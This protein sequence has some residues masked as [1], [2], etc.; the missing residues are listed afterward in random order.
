M[1]INISQGLSNS[2]LKVL[3]TSQNYPIRTIGHIQ[4]HGV[5]LVLQSS[6]LDII[7]VSANTNASLG[8]APESLLGKP[9]TVIFSDKEIEEL[10]ACLKQSVPLSTHTH[11]LTASI[12]GR[13]FEICLHPQN[14]IILLELEPQSSNASNLQK[15]QQQTCQIM[16]S[17]ESTDTILTFSQ[18]LAKEVRSLTHFDR[19]MIYQFLPDD[20]GVVIAEE[21]QENLE[22]Y[23]GLHYPATDIPAEARAIFLDL[24]VRWIPDVSYQPIPL[25]SADNTLT[26]QPL[27]LSTAWLRGVSPTHVEYLKNMGVA[28]S[29]TMPLIDRRGLWGLIACHHCQPTYI[30]TQ[31]RSVLALV[32]KIAS[33]GLLRQQSLENSH[34]QEKSNEL[35]TAL[36][37]ATGQNETSLHHVLSQNAD[38]LLDLFRA[39]GLA[40]IFDRDIVQVGDTPSKEDI[41]QLGRWLQQCPESVFSTST[42]R[43]DYPNDHDRSNLPA[44][45]LSV[46]VFLQK[47]HPISYCIM[48]FRAEQLK[49][50]S[51]AG[52]LDEST[53]VNEDG[54]LQLCPR[55]SFEIWKE[56]ISGQSLLWLSHELEAAL[57]LHS[58]LMLAA[59]NFSAEALENATQKAEVANRAK[60]EFLANMSHEIR[61]PMNGMLGMTELLDGT[62][63]D[64][65]QQDLVE[66]IR[67][68]GE[69]LLTVINDILDF[70]KIESNNL[71]LETGQLDLHSCIEEVL[72]LF[73]SQAE[74]KGLSLKV[75]IEPAD[76]PNFFKGDPVRLRQILSNLV[77]NCIKFTHQGGVSVYAKVCLISAEPDMGELSQQ[78]YKIQFA[79]KDSGIGI[80]QDKI[81]QL[82]QPFKQ[83]DASTTRK[84]GGTGLGLAIS[85]QLVEMMDGK[86]WIESEPNKGSTFH[87]YIELEA[88]P[89]VQE[90]E[91][92]AFFTGKRLLIVD[93]SEI[94]QK[95]L[96]MQAESWGL[97]VCAVDSAEAAFGKLF[98]SETFDVVLIN[99]PLP[100][101][102]DGQLV[103]Q[104][105]NFP[106]YGTVP[107]ILIQSQRNIFLTQ[108][109]LL[110]SGIR[111]LQKPGKRSQFY[112]AL[113]D[114]LLNEQNAP[115]DY[116]SV[117]EPI[118]STEIS[119]KPLRIL[120]VDDVPINQKVA[121]QILAT[122]GYRADTA[123]NGKEAV[124]AVQD[125][126]YD[127]VLMDVQMPEIDGLE[128]TRQ[129]RSNS[130]IMQPRIIAMTAHA[131]Q[132]DREECL[133]AGMDDYIQK[134]IRKND[135]GM[136]VQR[137]PILED[138]LVK[139]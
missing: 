44:G 81:Q 22:S 76:I 120:L 98:R 5:L 52:Q 13:T 36:R 93:S 63:L 86:I 127:L 23:L 25:I 75:L 17:L 95:Y 50:V 67:T 70:S 49:S 7:Q 47:P 24:P 45:L 89:Q 79:I 83:G 35:I 101:M 97:E 96:S 41:R 138:R 55:N 123:V 135:L 128:A 103:S 111:I 139:A 74:I 51:W 2:E 106:K 114:L 48:L 118:E 9:L 107:L 104:I 119:K 77:S 62:G 110:S 102:E 46:S 87:F 85:K 129:I 30:E 71:E 105:R 28:S 112:N 53:K 132:G 43:Q 34:Y 21:K 125:K 80:P 72:I 134:P 65:A 121:L 64:A 27:C 54:E 56:Q 115:N 40:L 88:Y 69:T 12:N 113:V 100:D 92:E 10:K 130:N 58:V 14:E 82:F 11:T 4:S 57:D 73:L 19:V 66:V 124:K 16:A 20:S 26:P 136:A 109:R 133:A 90:T 60:S 99:E 39:E 18:A 37:V 84:Y 117:E 94:S 137:C 31:N 78:R 15:L 131:M 68:S 59:L 1:I 108:T 6:N 122:Y 126:V 3:E 116:P 38:L 61:T 32:S 42:L 33:L 29:L 8:V 91:N